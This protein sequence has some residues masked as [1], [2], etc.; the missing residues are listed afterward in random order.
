M[1]KPRDLKLA[2]AILAGA[3]L[4][5]FALI[6]LGCALYHRDLTR[7][8]NSSL[9]VALGVAIVAVALIVLR[10]ATRY[11][12]RL[13]AEGIAQLQEH[14][15]TRAALKAARERPE[16]GSVSLS[17]ATHVQGGVSLSEDEAR[18]GALSE[19]QAARQR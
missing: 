12:G 13:I 4:L 16:A 3:S 10:F 7:A 19:H 11:Q 14:Q 8:L 17:E 15:R 9:V 2:S 6:L 18:Q 1:E 5:G